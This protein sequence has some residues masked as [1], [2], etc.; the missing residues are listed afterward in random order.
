MDSLIFVFVIA[1]ANL[2]TRYLQ[3]FIMP[4]EIPPFINYI[5]NILPNVIIAMLVVYCLK[6][7]NMLEPFYGLKEFLSILVVVILH[8]SIKIP[9][10]SILGGVIC[11]MILVQK[12][13]I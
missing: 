11:Y 8:I 5:S 9:I 2:I 10:V 6:D 1:I 4:K 3:Y 12:V 7:V 13:G